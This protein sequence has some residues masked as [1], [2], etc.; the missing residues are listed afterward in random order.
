VTAAVTVRVAGTVDTSNVSTYASAAFTPAAGELLVVMA[1][2]TAS[3]AAATC[4]ASANGLTFTRVLSQDNAP[5]TGLLYLFVADQLV[6]ASPVSMT[7]TVDVTGD[8]GTGSI[9]SVAGISG[10]TRAG[11]SAIRQATGAR[12]AAGGTPAVTMPAAALSANATLGFAQN[13]LSPAGLTPTTFFTEGGDVGYATPTTGQEW[14]YRNSGHASA[15][16]TWGSTSSTAWGA[17]VFEV[18]TSAAANS[19]TLAETLPAL[20]GVLA[21]SLAIVGTIPDTLPALTAALAV[22]LK[23]PGTLPETLPPLAAALTGALTIPGAMP[24]SLPALS[25]VLGGTVGAAT[26]TGVLTAPLPP[27]AGALAGALG[28]AG[29]LPDTLPHLTSVMAGSIGIAGALPLTLPHMTAALAGSLQ[30][31]GALPLTLPHMTAALATHVNVALNPDAGIVVYASQ[32][33]FDVGEWRKVREAAINV[34]ELTGKFD[35]GDPD[36]APDDWPENVR[37]KFGD[38]VAIYGRNTRSIASPLATLEAAE[39]VALALLGQRSQVQLIDY[40]FSSATIAWE[41]LDSD[42]RRSWGDQLWPRGGVEIM[43]RPFAVT[44]IP[45]S[46]R[47]VN[48]PVV[49]G[50]VMGVTLSIERKTIRLALASRAVPGRSAAGIDYAAMAALSPAVTFDNIDPAMTLDQ[51]SLATDSG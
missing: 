31:A 28:I 15:T 22:A 41:R 44:G 43:G 13:S 51:L 33:A 49:F 32:L 18:D 42:Q 29:T 36:I 27:M 40:G 20:T 3:I 47:L 24:D 19:G 37:A 26:T 35:P 48:G 16:L 10:V 30:I 46:W 2:V 12:G 5:V 6:P 21:G 50:R 38:L 8:A 17:I 9:I 11:L 4:V 7:V 34:L 45:D 14:Q 23:I 39:F 25:A 1:N